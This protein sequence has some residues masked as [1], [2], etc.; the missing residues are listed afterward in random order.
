MNLSK[1]EFKGLIIW[2]LRRTGGTNFTGKI[3]NLLKDRFRIVQHEP[4]NLDRI[5]GFITQ[6]FKEG[7]VDKT[8]D[9][10]VQEL[11]IPTLIKHCVETVPRDFNFLLADIIF[12]MCYFN[13]FFYFYIDK[14]QQI[15]CFLYILP[16]KVTFG[17][18]I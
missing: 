13:L 1:S 17:D 12:E 14:I 5:F 6:E 11:S 3:S 10:L 9:L 16:T 2:T 7:N 8:R 4:F 18:Q 15:G